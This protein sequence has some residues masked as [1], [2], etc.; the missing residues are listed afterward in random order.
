M[1]LL[2]IGWNVRLGHL[3]LLSTLNVFS[4]IDGQAQ[5]LHRAP[6]LVRL[7]EVR[8]GLRDLLLVLSHESR[9][10]ILLLCQLQLIEVFEGAQE[11]RRLLPMTLR[12]LLVIVVWSGHW[13][14]LAHPSTLGVAF[15]ASFRTLWA[16]VSLELLLTWAVD[17]V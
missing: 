4:V 3:G 15:L 5:F 1:L 6:D 13:R 7:E 10:G 11:R 16:L 14:L 9:L 17:C 8:I 12:E 2:E